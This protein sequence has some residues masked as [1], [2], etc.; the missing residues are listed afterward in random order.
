MALKDVITQ[1]S[2]VVAT[3]GN[4]L[5]SSVQ[6][7]ETEFAKA[8]PKGIEAKQFLRDAMSVLSTNPR[9]AEC[10]RNS[11]I[12]GL[13]TMAQLG[14]RPGVS[15]LGHG[16]LL[17]MRVSGQL[18]AQLIIGYQGWLAL[19][20]RSDKIESVEV[21]TVHEN[22]EFAVEYGTDSRLIHRPTLRGS[23]G[24]E[25][26]AYAVVKAGGG[27]YWEW[28]SQADLEEHRDR[29]AMAKKN[30]AIVGPWRDH[31]W[32]MAK[33][34][35][36]KRALWYA[37]RSTDII[38]SMAADE[39]VRLDTSPDVEPETVSVHVVTDDDGTEG[40]DPTVQAPFAPQEAPQNG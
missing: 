30:G 18:R 29:F 2:T 7:M 36:L 22:D 32:A 28:M 6:R 5:R 37:P 38:T 15:G 12:G 23:R 25:T 17:P 31:F 27:V 20:H 35:V 10:E 4:D 3:T 39:T 16:W 9:L 34:T 24:P 14:L 19:A 8:L 33:K 26:G 1:G 40:F 21:R 13:M 11:F